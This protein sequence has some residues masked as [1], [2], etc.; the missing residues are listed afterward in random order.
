MGRNASGGDF[1]FGNHRNARSRP[2]QRGE[3][4][5]LRSAV[6]FGNRGTVLLVLDVEA[7]TDDL[8]DRVPR[9]ARR[10]GNVFE[11]LLVLTQRGAIRMPPS[12]RIDSAFR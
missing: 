9:L 8:E 3:D 6:R 1:L 4:D 7:A 2:G 12:R 5:Q 11:E 10:Y